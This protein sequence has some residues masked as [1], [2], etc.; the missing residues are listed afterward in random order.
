MILF[1]AVW[2]PYDSEL[3]QFLSNIEQWIELTVLIFDVEWWLYDG[4]LTKHWQLIQY[5]FFM[6]IDWA[7]LILYTVRCRYINDTKS[8]YVYIR[9]NIKLTFLT[10]YWA[11]CVCW[12]AI[13]FNYFTAVGWILV[14]FDAEQWIEICWYLIL[15]DV[16]MILNQAMCIFDKI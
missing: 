10:G 1:D 15:Y 2:W 9:S 8:G 16:S 11:T 3:N 12:Y 6:T 7:M 13:L 14:I 5:D 4:V